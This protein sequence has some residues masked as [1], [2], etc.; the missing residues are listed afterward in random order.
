MR[1]EACLRMSVEEWLIQA[2][3]LNWM[4]K[5]IFAL[6]LYIYGEHSLDNVKPLLGLDITSGTYAA[7]GSVI[8]GAYNVI[9][10]VG[11]VLLVLYFLL[12]LTERV[13]METLTPE[14][15]IRLMC[16]L[17]IGVAIIN[18]G[19][20]LLIGA[21]NFAR[22]IF[23]KVSQSYSTTAPMNNAIIQEYYDRLNTSWL[24]VIPIAVELLLP[25]LLRLVTELVI[26]VIAFGR[27]LELAARGMFA[28]IGMASIFSGGF[29]SSGYR[30]FKK[31]LA[32]ALQGAVIAAILIAQTTIQA[33]LTTAG[34]ADV[35]T[36]VTAP[37]AHI[38]ISLTGM[39]LI[40]KSQGWANDIVGV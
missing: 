25:V 3:N 12:E 37:L 40:I 9:A 33:T 6:V 16:K 11:Y 1:K 35:W 39:T 8:Q 36:T 2:E 19:Y 17:L 24:H 26:Y 7:I 18:N 23:E 30:Y 27:M 38:I 22:G 20:D 31:F 10:S 28:P 21:A 14:H 5:S 34:G 13:Q 29:N 15:F 32:V 4:A